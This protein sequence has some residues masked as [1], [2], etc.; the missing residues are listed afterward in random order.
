MWI[1]RPVVERYEDISLVFVAILSDSLSSY[2][3]AFSQLQ[4]VDTKY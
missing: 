3:I 2:S 4:W 1:T